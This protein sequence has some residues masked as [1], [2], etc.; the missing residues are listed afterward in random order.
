MTQ[1]LFIYLFLKIHS[2]REMYRAYKER[3]WVCKWENCSY[4]LPLQAWVWLF[5]FLFFF[6]YFN[7]SL[8]EML[9]DA[10]ELCC[11]IC[12]PVCSV[13]TV[14]CIELTGEVVPLL[15]TLAVS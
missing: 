5:F 15:E 10:I 13:G 1:H 11:R 14:V 3:I 8:A 6:F 7:Y 9:K 2:N 12:K 4:I